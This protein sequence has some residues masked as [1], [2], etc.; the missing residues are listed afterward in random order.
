MKGISSLRQHASAHN[1]LGDSG[2]QPRGPRVGDLQPSNQ[3]ADDNYPPRSRDARPIEL[4]PAICGF[5]FLIGALAADAGQVI[6]SQPSV[7]DIRNIAL[8]DPTSVKANTFNIIQWTKN[9]NSAAGDVGVSWDVG[10]YTGFTP[11]G[12][13]TKKQLGVSATSGTTAMQA[14]GIQLGILIDSA[15]LLTP[16]TGDGTLFPTVVQY[17]FAAANQFKPFLVAGN[18]L[19]FAM[20]A[21]VPTGTGSGSC[22]SADSAC[23]Y[24]NLYFDVTD[25]SSGLQFWYGAVLFDS[26]GTPNGLGSLSEDIMFDGNTHQAIVG[27][28]INLSAVDG[29]QFTTAFPTSSG[30]QSSP[31]AGYQAF[32]FAISATNMMNAATAVKSRFPSQYANLSTNPAEYAVDSFNFN[33]EV[34]YFGGTARIGVSAR[35]IRISVQDSS[36]CYNTFNGVDGALGISTGDNRFLCSQTKWYSCGWPATPGENWDTAVAN[37]TVVGS[38]TCDLR[39]SAW[40]SN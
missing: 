18:T 3:P 4:R 24:A 33:P 8:V 5:V 34:A 10:A 12:N 35:A 25:V 37:G 9:P 21:Q 16:G 11:T 29:A 7:N 15:S 17:N 39:A 1:G 32:Q 31:W 6:Y 20:E 14:Q 13:L 2:L 27:G 22:G 19:V 40:M 36:D 38:Y 28:V 26:R 23:S 30:F